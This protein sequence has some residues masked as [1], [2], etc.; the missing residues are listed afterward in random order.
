MSSSSSSILRFA[1]ASARFDSGEQHDSATTAG[2]ETTTKNYQP[3]KQQKNLEPFR[4]AAK[5]VIIPHD[6][7]RH[8]GGEDAAANS[9]RLLVVADGVGGWASKGVNPGLF[10]RLLVK[11]IQTTFGINEV[12]SKQNLEINNDND[13]SDNNAAPSMLHP[14]YLKHLVHNANHHA[15][16]EHLGSATCTVVRLVE[17]NVLETL[18]V[19]DSG[20]SIHRRNKDMEQEVMMT[21]DLG[22]MWDVVYE[23]K[24]GQ[25]GFNFPY[26]LGGKHGDSVHD[27]GVCDGP[28]THDLQP[29]DVIVV[30]SDGVSD[31]MTPEQYNSC[32]EQFSWNKY[33]TLF[34]PTATTFDTLYPNFF[35]E[36]ELM[37][38][39]VVADCIAR[40]AYQLGKNK[41]HN[42]PFAQSAK[43]YGKNYIGGKH[44]DITVTVAQVERAYMNKNTKEYHFLNNLETDDPHFEDL[45]YVYKDVDE[46]DID[47]DNKNVTGD[48]T[49][50][51]KKKKKKKIHGLETLPQMGDILKTIMYNVVHDGESKHHTG[52][53]EF[54]EEEEEEQDDM[55]SSIIGEEL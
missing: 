5:T 42:S 8:R 3:Q 18:N 28:K 25:K 19:G 24:P 20:Y 45:V 17:E 22:K 11:T 12:A 46:D 29:K 53:E 4:F 27:H 33:L 10:S 1:E 23:S 36:N 26:Q 54:E 13:G 48:N 9:D 55:P 15:A 50:S 44:D 21:R 7:K 40:T 6:D 32:I 14:S 51:K 34:N 41:S 35:D 43:S 16:S 39:S 30:V 2:K 31:N 47:A 49:E 38:Y 37:S 52:D